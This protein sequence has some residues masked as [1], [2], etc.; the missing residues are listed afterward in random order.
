MLIFSHVTRLYTPLGPSIYYLSIHRYIHLSVHWT[1]FDFW[2]AAPK[3]IKSSRTQ[4]TSVR[5][6]VCLIVRSSPQALS[7]LKSTL[8]GLK[9]TLSGMKSALESERARVWGFNKDEGVTFCRPIV[10]KI[11]KC[12]FNFFNFS[13]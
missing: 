4:G 9:S 13:F 7:S 6:S 5:S 8:S 1:P 3:G 12:V 2:A 11:W 10:C